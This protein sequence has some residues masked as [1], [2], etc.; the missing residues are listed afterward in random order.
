L[1]RF[2]CA[3]RHPLRAKTLSFFFLPSSF[4]DRTG[5]R[6]HSVRSS[7]LLAGCLKH[8]KSQV[9]SGLRNT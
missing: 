7:K 6:R 8:G 3:N 9:A 4:F 2:L 1:T 5:Q